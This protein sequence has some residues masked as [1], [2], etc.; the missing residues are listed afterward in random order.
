MPGCASTAF[1]STTGA[2]PTAFTR[3]CSTDSF[4]AS[5]PP[6]PGGA[7]DEPLCVAIVGAGATGVELAAELNNVARRFKGLGFD[8]LTDARP[9]RIVLIEAGPRILPALPQ[10]VA[11]AAAAELERIGV[12]IRCACK[13]RE[14]TADGVGLASGE[15]VAAQFKVWAAGVKAPP[16]LGDLDGLETNRIHQLVVGQNLATTRDANIFAIG[17]CAACPRPGSD[18]PVPPRSQ[19]AHQQAAVLARSVIRR[20]NGRPPLDFVY[21]DYGALVSLARLSVGNLMGK[22]RGSLFIE[23]WLAHLAYRMLYR[24]HQ[25]TVHGAR[26]T[27]L[28]MAAD[29]LTRRIRPRLKLH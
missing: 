22:L 2:R 28:V 23:G 8:H 11:T 27:L 15:T 26:R 4:S 14:V 10:R 20:L 12:E 7:A 6:A 9:I 21:R 17:D 13:V 3:C 5:T 24:S 16:F 25:W 18:R 1:S 19:A 29:F